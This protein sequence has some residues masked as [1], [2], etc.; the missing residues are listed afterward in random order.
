MALITQLE[1]QWQLSGDLLID[2]MPSVLSQASGLTLDGDTHLDFSQVGEVDTSTISFI[3]ELQRRANAS[4]A[5]ILLS[6]PPENL[7]NLMTLY[8]VEDFIDNV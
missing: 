3:L 7:L 1:N 6:H 5:K 8:G 4:D 2:E